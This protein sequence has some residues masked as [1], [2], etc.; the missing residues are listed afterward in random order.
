MDGSFLKHFP[1]L[2]LNTFSM[3]VAYYPFFPLS[4]THYLGDL[5]NSYRFITIY[6]RLIPKFR[7]CFD[8]HCVFPAA[9]NTCIQSFVKIG[10][11]HV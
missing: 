7:L 2:S 5:I 10:R 8:S 6:M 9:S 1:S 3:F 11:A 4:S